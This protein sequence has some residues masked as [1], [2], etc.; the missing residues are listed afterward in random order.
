MSEATIDFFWED[1]DVSW[2][3]AGIYSVMDHN[4]EAIRWLERAIDHGSI[5]Y[6]LFAELDPFYENIRSDERFQKLMEKIKPE[7]EHFEVG[8]DLSGLPPASDD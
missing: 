4:D 1:P 3:I 2:V 7:W 8:I 5:N 6:P